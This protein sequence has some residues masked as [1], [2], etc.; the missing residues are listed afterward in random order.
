MGSTAEDD[1]SKDAKFK[2]VKEK[3]CLTVRRSGSRDGYTA[4]LG[5]GEMGEGASGG[6]S[7]SLQTQ[8]LGNL[9]LISLV[10]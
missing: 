6:R 3:P 5:L 1:F 7:S 8:A 9:P 2:V 10:V 4:E